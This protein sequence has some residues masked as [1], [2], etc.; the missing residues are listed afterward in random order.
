MRKHGHSHGEYLEHHRAFFGRA[1]N[2]DPV[3]LNAKMTAQA[4]GQ[5]SRKDI[6][7]ITNIL[8]DKVLVRPLRKVSSLQNESILDLPSLHFGKAR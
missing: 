6:K 7:I 8:V 4:D 2:L 1:K 3:D 5:N